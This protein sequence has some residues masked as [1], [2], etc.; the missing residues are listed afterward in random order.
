M[1]KK[2]TILPRQNASGLI[3][4]DRFRCC[5]DNLKSTARIRPGEPIP[6]NPATD[7]AQYGRRIFQSDSNRSELKNR[8]TGRF[9]KSVE[10]A[11][12]VT[13]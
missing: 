11:Y 6:M 4:L 10:C 3:K 9:F 7:F 5:I 8:P 2:R 12:L 1:L 13:R